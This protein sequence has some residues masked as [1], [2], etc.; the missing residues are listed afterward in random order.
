V[1][2]SIEQCLGGIF[3]Q[4]AQETVIGTDG[5]R[6]GRTRDDG[7]ERSVHIDDGRS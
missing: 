4:N 7:L 6:T 5:D 3:G 2:K 1:S